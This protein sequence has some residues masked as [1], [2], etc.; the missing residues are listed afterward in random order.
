MIVKFRS[1][2]ERNELYDHRFQLQGKTSKDLGFSVS[3]LLFINENLTIDRGHLLHEVRE[4]VKV[5][6][7]GKGKDDAFRVKTVQGIIKVMNTSKNYI[8][9]NTFSDVERMHPS[10]RSPFSDM[11]LR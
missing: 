2:D 9:I 11:S 5:I 3:K 4:H 8:P 1:K 6:N 10:S 7:Q